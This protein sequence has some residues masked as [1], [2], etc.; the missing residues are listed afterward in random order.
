MQGIALNGGTIRDAQ[1]RD[2]IAET[3][4]VQTLTEHRVR[5]GLYAMWLDVEPRRRAIEG[6]EL[7]IRVKRKGSFDEWAVMVIEVTDNAVGTTSN[8]NTR[9]NT[10]PSEGRKRSYPVWFAAGHQH[11]TGVSTAGR[12][13]TPKPAN[14]TPNGPRLLTVRIV[15]VDATHLSNTT[16]DCKAGRPGCPD[17]PPKPFDTTQIQWHKKGDPEKGQPASFTVRVDPPG[18]QARIGPRIIEFPSVTAPGEETGYVADERIEARVE[19][20]APVTV[21]TTRGTPTLGLA[22]G[23]VRRETTY[24]SG[25]GSTD[26]GVRAHRERSRRG[27]RGRQSDRQRTDGERRTDP[28][29]ERETR[30]P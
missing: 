2:T 20:E 11:V 6:E 30:E 21:D 19:F 8:P 3:F 7:E 18:R 9:W 29:R 10:D 15:E 5:G 13:I 28:R 16:P 14:Q 4:P 23:G 1:A 26:A 12:T 24:E 25:S 22:L 17:T 27:R